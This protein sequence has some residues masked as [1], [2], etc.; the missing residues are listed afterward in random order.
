MSQLL[1]LIFRIRNFLLFA[2]LELVSFWL[3][4]KNSYYWDVSFFN[5]SNYYAAKTLEASNYIKSFVN[6]GKVNDQ[7]VRENAELKKAMAA[8]S[9]LKAREGDYYKV[10]SAF[11]TRFD[12]KVAKVVNSTVSLSKNYLTIDKGKLD[13][14]EPGMGVICPQGVVG[15][16]MQ[17]SDHFSR[18]YSILHS[19]F[20]VSSEVNNQALRSKNEKALGIA[21][22]GGLNPRVIDLTT[23]DRFKPI[24]KGDSVVTS[25]QNVIFPSG[26][27]V[28]K[29]RKLGAKQD[30]A[31][32]DIE[33]ELTTDFQNISYVYV[34]N[35]KLKNEQEK[36]E[37]STRPEIKK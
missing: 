4:V 23:I 32:F 13:G 5:T 26:T 29:I 37:E 15:Q 9:Q 20:N 22:W 33:V 7:L 18:V 2:I 11:A 31:F 16:V 27:M 17:C 25:E 19:E 24:K 12:F 10:D 3:I 28:G 34:V 8:L 36:L 30:Q 35:N 6:L 1:R 14:I 21:K